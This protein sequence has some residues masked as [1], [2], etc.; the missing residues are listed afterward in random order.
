VYKGFHF[1]PLP[2]IP[3]PIW[4]GIFICKGIYD[5]RNPNILPEMQNE[6]FVLERHY[7]N[8]NEYA[9]QELQELFI[10]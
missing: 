7:E 4:Y 1:S 5:E 2:Y 9:M 3:V 8:G 10:V 6:G